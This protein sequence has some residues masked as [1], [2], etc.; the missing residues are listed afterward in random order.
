MSLKRALLIGIN[1]YPFLKDFAQLTGCHN[2]VSLIENVLKGKFGFDS[3]NIV[4]LLS[5]EATRCRI[6][7]EM[8]A[9]V[10]NCEENE[11]VVF[12][13]SGHGSRLNGAKRKKVSGWSETIMPF[14]SGRKSTHPQGVNRD[15]T[16]DEIYGWLMALSKKTS[17]I[18][19][20]FDSCFS[21]SIIR[22][23]ELKGRKG[24]IDHDS[25]TLRDKSCAFSFDE[26]EMPEKG[27][28][29]WLPLSD[30][31]VLLSA[32][33]EYEPANVF[34][35][36]DVKGGYGIFTYYLH[37]AL[38]DAKEGD[39]YRSVW[40][41][42]YVGVKSHYQDQNPQIEGK[43]DRE[44][45]GLKEFPPFN[46]LTLESRNEEDV[47]LS[48]G[49]I[50]DVIKDSEWNIYQSGT[51]TFDEN[52]RTNNILGRIKVLSPD[53]LTSKA[54]ILK[55]TFPQAIQAGTRAVEVFRPRRIKTLRVWI[56][57][58]ADNFRQ[59]RENLKELLSESPFWT[60]TAQKNS[61]DVRIRLY[62][63][64]GNNSSNSSWNGTATS[65]YW[66]IY[67]RDE[68]LIMSPQPLFGDS[69]QVKDFTENL[70]KL[71]RYHHILNLKN[72]K[73]VLKGKV[74]F[75]ILC[76]D[77]NKIWNKVEPR[78]NNQISAIQQSKRIALRIINR[79]EHPIYFTI[80]DFGL[81]KSVSLIYPPPGANILIGHC[82][83][84]NSD[85]SDKDMGIFTIGKGEDESFEL[86][87]PEEFPFTIP[88]IGNDASNKKGLEIY[89]LF[90]TTRPHDLSFLLQ[91]GVRED[92]QI[93]AIT[94]MENLMFESFRGEAPFFGEITL[95]PCKDEWT[96]IEKPFYLIEE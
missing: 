58:C 55:E 66:L 27:R 94:E 34:E 25:E 24:G 2:D 46:F 39:T 5:E 59:A 48:G 21:S 45:F 41:Q 4:T 40:E 22:D 20:I 93:A 70:N 60:I 56:D 15:I 87:F 12:F 31:Y 28:S 95:A 30:K 89:K 11:T 83:S 32:S 1:T 61:A 74:D 47:I 29:G 51:K 14:D 43:R 62:Q 50:H 37:N 76:Q 81:S 78:G 44:L 92:Q 80:L 68:Q 10:E 53:P 49:I 82:N 85:D 17:N 72:P 96:T 91:E 57:A 16:D 42:L 13:F 65:A 52:G 79:F 86:S 71:A 69:F 9:L 84:E 33:L 67:G 63:S 26:A 8:T 77:E 38:L 35:S 19:L 3:K 54:I 90:I 64:D 7:R 23:E 36:E 88:E 73:S 18:I 6:I 75:E